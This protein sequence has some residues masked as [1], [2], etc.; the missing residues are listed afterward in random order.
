VSIRH[1][2]SLVPTK[3]CAECRNLVP[4]DDLDRDGR[5]DLCVCYGVWFTTY[6]IRQRW[7]R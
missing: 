7:S 5:C 3:R 4:V 2:R 1:S 6:R